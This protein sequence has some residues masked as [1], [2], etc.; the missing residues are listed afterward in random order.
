LTFEREPDP[1]SVLNVPR[2]ASL[3]EIRAAYQELA[4]KYHPDRHQGNPLEDLASAR[5]VEINRAYEILSDA[6][7]RAAYDA[8][9][10][11][12]PDRAP[13]DLRAS[14]RL[15]LVVF[16]LLLVPLVAR[17]GAIVVRAVTRLA[18][19]VFEVAAS[20]PGGRPAA[21][22]LLAL[23]VLAGAWLRRRRS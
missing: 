19:E 6:T 17:T 13:P 22:T 21:V 20:M 10:V 5:L 11:S 9:G 3:A 14:K 1:Y 18:R 2:S 7:S 16:I 15:R 23:V 8:G 12:G 4:R